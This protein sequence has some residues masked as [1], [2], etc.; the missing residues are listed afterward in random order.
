ML[1]ISLVLSV[2]K[3]PIATHFLG[4]YPPR[5]FLRGRTGIAG[6]VSGVRLGEV[7]TLILRQHR[8]IFCN[9]RRLFVSL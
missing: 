4:G 5:Q 6:R 9:G 7:H 1:F 2:E 8:I 3:C